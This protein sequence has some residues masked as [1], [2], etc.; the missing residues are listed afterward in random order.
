MSKTRDELVL[1]A[2]ERLSVV[3]ENRPAYPNETAIVDRGVDPLLR[4]LLKREI[5]YVPDANDIDDAVFESIA[6]LLAHA[7]RGFF[8]VAT[9]PLDADGSSPVDWAEDKLREIGYGRYSGA[10]QQGEY[11]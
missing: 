10:V 2:L 7:V 6:V 3:G 8:G 5:I 9:L 11:M 1:R 4:E